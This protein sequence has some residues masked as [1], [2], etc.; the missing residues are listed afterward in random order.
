M[1]KELTPN[2]VYEAPETKILEINTGGGA[3]LKRKH[4]TASGI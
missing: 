1:T 3:L 4:G 2:Q